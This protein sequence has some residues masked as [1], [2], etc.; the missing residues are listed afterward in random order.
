MQLHARG[1]G[2]FQKPQNQP[3]ERF[4]VRGAERK[5]EGRQTH[6]QIFEA[7]S[8]AGKSAS[9][10]AA[11]CSFVLFSCFRGITSPSR[12]TPAEPDCFAS[13]VP[14]FQREIPFRCSSIES[15]RLRVRLE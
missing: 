7:F 6:D 8:A 15:S 1:A 9:G 14:R 13:A 4:F 3:G 5:P 12:C 10:A 11:L 2:A